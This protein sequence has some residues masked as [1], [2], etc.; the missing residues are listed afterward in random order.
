MSVVRYRLFSGARKGRFG[1]EDMEAPNVD[2]ELF[3]HIS[4]KMKAG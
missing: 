1:P 4:H 2:P 3:D